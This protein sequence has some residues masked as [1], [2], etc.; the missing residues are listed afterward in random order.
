MSRRELTIG[1]SP[2]PQTACT[3]W[4]RKEALDTIIKD[5][6]GGGRIVGA[7]AIATENDEIVYQGA[8]GFADREAERPVKEGGFCT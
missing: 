6:V 7:T 3:A 2:A 4:D 5:A 1:A 8:A